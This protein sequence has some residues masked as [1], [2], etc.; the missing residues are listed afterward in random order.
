MSST[1][2]AFPARAFAVNEINSLSGSD[3][4]CGGRYVPLLCARCFTQRYC[5]PRCQRQHWAE[6]RAVCSPDRSAGELDV[7]RWFADGLEN[8]A[9]GTELLTSA[10]RAHPPLGLRQLLEARLRGRLHTAAILD[11]LRV[12]LHQHP[13]L[14]QAALRLLVPGSVAPRAAADAPRA[15]QAR[16]LPFWFRLHDL[17]SPHCL[18]W[19][20]R[21]P[22][23]LWLSTGGP[24]HRLR[25]WHL[26]GAPAADV[27]ALPASVYL[28]VRERAPRPPEA[29]WL[30]YEA[31]TAALRHDEGASFVAAE[32]EAIV[33]A[34]ADDPWNATLPQYRAELGP[35]AVAAATALAAR[36]WG[37]LRHLLRQLLRRRRAV[38]MDRISRL[39][40]L[41]P[42]IA[43]LPS[44]SQRA[45][46]FRALARACRQLWEGGLAPGLAPP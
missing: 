19:L 39:Q 38:D 33:P 23:C 25:R 40:L 14:L 45:A 6:H 9:L 3:C 27:A 24:V 21:Y 15:R 44:A 46:L 13:V 22:R 28:C 42:L 43:R 16:V 35:A 29:E 4:A 34:T 1:L 37:R 41:E 5:S 18:I 2:A 31:D 12:L 10:A 17:D 36:D 7:Q 11:S 30:L 8:G 32:L 26:L 20:A